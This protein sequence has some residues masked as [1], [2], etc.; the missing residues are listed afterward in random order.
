MH[1]ARLFVK[2]G[3][4]VGNTPGSVQA[5]P[6]VLDHFTFTGLREFPKSQ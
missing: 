5:E 3:R 6:A 1:A 4:A 2:G